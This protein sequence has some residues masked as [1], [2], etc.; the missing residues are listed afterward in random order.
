M[1]K[2]SIPNLQKL[3]ELGKV[4]FIRVGVLPL[5]LVATVVIFS[6]WN[7]AFLS[8]V[9]LVVVSREAT[10]LIMVT[11][12]QMLALL[13]AGF[14]LS[15]GATVALIS[16]VSATVM[17]SLQAYPGVDVLVGSLVGIGIGALVGVSNGF[18]IAFFRISPFLVTLGMSFIALS[19]SLILSGGG[20]PV[21]GLPANFV[22]TLGH[23]R[24]LG[25]P[26]PVIVT[27]LLIGSV[28]FILSWTRFGRYIYALGGSRDAA[29]RVGIPVR[30]YTVFTYVAV[31][32]LVGIS[33]VMMT[34]RT[35]SGEPTLGLTLPLL[36]ISAAV[37]GGISLFGGEGKL[38]G[39]ILGAIAIT[40]IQNGMNLVGV[41]SFVQ[42]VIMGA[43][44][45][46]TLA[47]EHYR[48]QLRTSWELKLRQ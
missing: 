15:L 34:A 47:S 7:P 48:R 37:I 20:R 23:G 26:V 33:G 6:I 21:Y 41:D 45:I 13:S 22:Y 35:G 30:R 5:L 43:I 2:N 8:L 9:N 17:L 28:Y 36:S 32:I 10:Y 12:A 4:A 18:F 38:Y 11:L 25:I 27:I 19:L 16:V 46:M 40:L 42:M 1:V 29:V 3:L 24:V 44:L 39:A 31:G 14:D